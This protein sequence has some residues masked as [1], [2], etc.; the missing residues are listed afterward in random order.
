MPREKKQRGSPYLTATRYYFVP[1]CFKIEHRETIPYIESFSRQYLNKTS[2]GEVRIRAPQMGVTFDLTL[3]ELKAR[4]IRIGCTRFALGGGAN[5]VEKRSRNSK[6]TLWCR[7]N[8]QKYTYGLPFPTGS[9]GGD[10][11]G[12]T[13]VLKR[14]LVRYRVCKLRRQHAVSLRVL[15]FIYPQYNRHP[16]AKIGSTDRCSRR[17]DK[18]HI[19]LATVLTRHV[20]AHFALTCPSWKC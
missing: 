15:Q 8:T 14:N 19:K 5:T 2:A 17:M 6:C 3:W 16:N 12:V 10:I 18:K 9:Y 20:V 1:I 13:V 4:M 11:R 7:E